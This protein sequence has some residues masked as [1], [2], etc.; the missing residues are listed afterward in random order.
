MRTLTTAHTNA[1]N[2]L[3][4]DSLHTAV[5]PHTLGTDVHLFALSLLFHRPIFQ[6]N[7]F[8][9]NLP[10]STQR[11]LT[12]SNTRDVHHFADRFHNREQLTRTHILY[13][14]NAIAVA[15]SEGDV[16]NLPHSPLTRC[17]IGN[18]HWIAMLPQS[19]CVLNSI[20]IPTTRILCE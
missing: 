5:T 10:N 19:P 16:T 13:C 1:C 12:L 14:D 20:P 18:V 7:T 15:L 9:F 4:C 17:H 3:Y 6:Y 2:R 11:E 8:Y